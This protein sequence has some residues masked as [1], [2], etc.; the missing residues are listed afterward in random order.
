MLA[1]LRSIT[2]KSV[3]LLP[4]IGMRSMSSFDPPEHKLFMQAKPM[5]R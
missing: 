3:Q 1:N 4:R 2:K 5:R